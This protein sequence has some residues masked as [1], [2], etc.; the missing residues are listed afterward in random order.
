MTGDPPD[1]RQAH[2]DG[3][4]SCQTAGRKTGMT[5]DLLNRLQADAD[6]WRAARR[7]EV[8]GVGALDWGTGL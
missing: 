3:L 5:G 7:G 6:E 8:A 1:R 2:Q 4:L